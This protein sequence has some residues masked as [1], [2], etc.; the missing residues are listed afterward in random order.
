M[1]QQFSAFS[2]KV[3]NK[4]DEALDLYVD[5]IIVDA[6]TQTILKNW[7]GDETSTS[8]KSF[9]DQ[10]TAANPKSINLF[11]NSDGGMV[12]DA[13]AIHDFMVDLESKG[14]VVNRK[15]RGLA[16][17][18]AT[19][20]AMGK[21]SSMSENSWLMIHNASGVAWGNVDD[22]ERYA[23]TARKINNSIVSFYSKKT[24]MSEKDIQD[25]MNKETWMNAEEAKSKGFID[26]IDGKETFSNSIKPEH[27]PY[28]NT[29][30]LNFYNSNVKGDDKKS[31]F[32]DLKQ[33]FMNLINDLKSS[34]AGAKK[35]DK[36]KDV[37]KRD[38][39]LDMVES[40]LTPI[41]N[42]I[43]E[44]FKDE[45]TAGEKKDEKKEEKAAEKKDEKV[46]D[47]KDEK[48]EEVEDDAT[49]LQKL[50]AELADMKKAMAN[51]LG[52]PANEK[53]EKASKV[54]AKIEYAD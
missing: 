19:F 25:M 46:A 1:K 5:G 43:D 50:K 51:K 49:E 7:F 20:L 54:E 2:Y 52:K 32:S 44:K 4:A 40:V 53:G 36:F 22:L 14:V 6:E 28:S 47:K 35:D 12:N 18:A 41:I 9:R 13:M 10:V 23:S 15:V 16:A 45:E 42:K 27:W 31:F 3:V 21:N 29:A 48:K 33:D 8:Y 38:A 34:V 39:V 17:S 11:I 37:E 24:G 30:V 26:S